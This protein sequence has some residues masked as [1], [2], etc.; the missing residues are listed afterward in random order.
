[1]DSSNLP[2]QFMEVTPD[3]KVVW[4][5]KAWEEPVNLGPS[6]IIQFLDTKEKP[7]NVRFGPIH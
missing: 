7:E 4:A 3:K 2:V 1:M 6:T 5:L